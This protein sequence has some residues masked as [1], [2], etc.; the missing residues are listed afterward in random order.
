MTRRTT[1]ADAERVVE[2]ADLEEFVVDK[3]ETWR[4]SGAK[5]R[6]RQRRYQHLLTMQLT[7]LNP[8]GAATADPR[9]LFSERASRRSM[10]TRARSGRCPAD[11][12]MRGSPHIRAAGTTLTADRSGRSL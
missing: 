10:T 11:V 8:R 9:R 5:A 4:G 3:R 2:A 12:V 6:R 7:K 1:P